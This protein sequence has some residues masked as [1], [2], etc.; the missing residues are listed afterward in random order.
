MGEA[1]QN[2]SLGNKRNNVVSLS[3]K[4]KKPL[5][6]FQIGNARCQVSNYHSVSITPDSFKGK[7]Q[8]LYF[9]PLIL[10]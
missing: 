10:K 4:K 9:T 7:K 8:H 3:V 1:E 5:C 6:V 2:I